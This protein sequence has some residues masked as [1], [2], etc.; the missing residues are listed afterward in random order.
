MGRE[1]VLIFPH[2]LFARHPALDP[3]RVVY[4]VEADRF[5][6]EFRFCRHKLVFHRASM[7]AYQA[8]LEGEGY[9]V[10]YVTHAGPE[11]IPRLFSALSDAG[12]STIRLADPCDHTLE[13]ILAQWSRNL[14]IRLSYQESP[15]FMT[16]RNLI[17]D[18]FTKTS[19]YSMTE[20]YREQRTRLDILMVDGKPAG[21]R[22]TYDTENRKP[23]PEGLKL[24]KITPPPENEWT[25]EA[26]EYV[27]DTFPE[28]PGQIQ[29]FIYPVTH[30]DAEV[31]LERFLA[32]RLSCFG[33]YQDAISF[34]N[35]FI[36]HSLLSPLLNTGLLTPDQVVTRALQFAE[37][38][39]VPINSLEGF[40]RQIIGWREFM[41]G[42]YLME[43]ETARR[44]NFWGVA[45]KMPD[46]LSEGTTGI[47]P[48]DTVVRN[49]RDR[50]YAH[51]IER[52][53]VLGNFMLLCEI[54]PDEVYRWFMENFIDAY[55]WVMVPNVYGMSQYAD[56]GLITTKPYI[57]TS[58]FLTRM[59]NYPEGRWCEIWD[60]L[61]W[62]FIARYRE[63]FRRNP[64]MRVLVPMLERME[65]ATIRK[66]CETAD[67]FL[68]R[69]HGTG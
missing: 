60:G 23:V 25:R 1:V 54:H 52:L 8:R 59:A 28:N 39:P 48:V 33:P 61:F 10:E 51:H 4:L 64:R 46:S 34:D 55:D 5:F 22:W 35:P 37:I 44:S 68:A 31:W 66:H 47:L 41:R 7:R 38:Y 15:G 9:H 24:A 26:E 14:G 57:S 30:K 16:P 18:F 19:H 6:S 32:N 42:V 12:I 49:V 62:R 43:G 36:C 2:Q 53:M 29:G 65:E 21:G 40:I 20:F 27:R 11:T 45:R 50:A 67:A 13:R 17:E 58:Q 3:E 69:F 63:V 56:G